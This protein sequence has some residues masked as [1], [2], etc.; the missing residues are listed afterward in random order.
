MQLFHLGFIIST[1][2]IALAN[3]PRD[4]LALLNVADVHQCNKVDFPCLLF[5]CAFPLHM[6]SSLLEMK[7]FFSHFSV[8]RGMRL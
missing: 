1:L 7:D 3:V 6:E 8:S 2:E 4:V 5:L